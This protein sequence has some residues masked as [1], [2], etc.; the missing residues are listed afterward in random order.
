MPRRDGNKVFT[1]RTPAELRERRRKMAE[2]E[3]VSRWW[4]RKWD[5][6]EQFVDYFEGEDEEG[7]VVY[8]QR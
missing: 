1:A 3:V 6:F 8:E 2:R 4:G 7:N 5:G